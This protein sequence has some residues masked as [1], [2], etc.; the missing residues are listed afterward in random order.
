VREGGGVSVPEQLNSL[1]PE[2]ASD[3][4]DFVE[5]RMQDAGGTVAVIRRQ[6]QAGFESVVTPAHQFRGRLRVGRAATDWLVAALAVTAAGS[7]GL[8]VG[9]ADVAIGIAI[10]ATF[11]IVVGLLGGYR[12]ADRDDAVAPI[13]AGLAATAF[14]FALAY[15][16]SEGAVP[17]DRL[18]A[19][20]WLLVALEVVNALVW[21]WVRRSS[22]VQRS[23]RLPAAVIVPA[24]DDDVSELLGALED[25]DP[26]AII[27]GPRL[28][29]AA[30]TDAGVLTDTV[31]RILLGSGAEC[32][33]VI[34][35]AVPNDELEQLR[36]LARRREADLRVMLRVPETLPTALRVRASN[37]GRAIVEVPRTNLTRGPLMAKRAMD[38]VLGTVAAVLTLPIM[39]AIAAAIRLTSPGPVMFRQERTTTHGRRFKIL[40]FRTMEVDA[41][42]SVEDTTAPFFKMADDPRITRVGRFIRPFS[43]DELPQL[44]NV[45]RGDMS[46][47]GPRPLPADQVEANDELLGPRHDVPAGMTGWW[48]VNGRSDLPAEEAV[49]FD[50]FY[51]ENWSVGLDLRILVKTIGVLFDRRGAY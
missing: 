27:D 41:E 4:D 44:W 30:R 3:A 18:V 20:A 34:D 49:V 33:L 25:L 50:R 46:L 8:A 32:L 13:A 45:L 5:V 14:V 29:S 36:R 39:L 11:P 35:G 16:S 40:K 2:T 48:Q 26:V 9:F 38:L 51:I 23:V 19:L 7:A 37:G 1:N 6:E 28:G 12:S 24:G 21:H 31:D 43:L 42:V 17:A 10:G 15:A 22:S 47:V